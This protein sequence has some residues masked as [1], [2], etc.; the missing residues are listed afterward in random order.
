MNDSSTTKYRVYMIHSWIHNVNEMALKLCIDDPELVS[1]MIWDPDDPQYIFVSEQIFLYQDKLDDYVRL[2][3]K[4]E[5]ESDARIF[6]MVDHE[7]LMPDLNLFDYA[8]CFDNRIKSDRIGR[9]PLLMFF[10]SSIV[11]INN[12]LTLEDAH[13]LYHVKEYCNF[14]YTNPHA[15]SIR[16]NLYYKLNEYKPVASTGH[17]LHNTDIDPEDRH[18]DWHLE[19]ILIKSRYRFSIACENACYPGYTTEKLL[20]SFQA[21]TVPIYW[22]NPDVSLEYNPD[23]FINASD[24]KDLND[25]LDVVKDIDNNEDKWCDLVVKP[26]IMES[27]LQ[28]VISDMKQYQQ[29]INSIFNQNIDDAIRRPIGYWPEI[30]KQFAMR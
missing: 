25:L 26:Y 21:H 19:S 7:C 18:P 27:Q 22:G 13:A 29:F 17:H 6:I 8:I 2:F 10:N 1:H 4:S 20:S 24:Y 28:K 15:P 30:Y 11:N 23:A 3:R 5:K 9:I 16:D 14:M 12:D